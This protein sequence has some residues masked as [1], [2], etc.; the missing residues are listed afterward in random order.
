MYT[1]QSVTPSVT[2]TISVSKTPSLSLSPVH[3]HLVLHL[4]YRSVEHRLQ[5]T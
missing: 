5:D 1:C 3:E 4:V 2:P